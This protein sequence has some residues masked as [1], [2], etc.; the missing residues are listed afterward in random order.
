MELLLELLL[1]ML[2]GIQLEMGLQM[3]LEMQL[4]M[5]EWSKQENAR[6]DKDP[7]GRERIQKVL[8]EAKR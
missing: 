7:A 8:E 1:E 5:Q 2:L 6:L 3:G 4:E